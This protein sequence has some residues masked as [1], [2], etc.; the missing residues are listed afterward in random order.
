MGFQGWVLRLSPKVGSNCYALRLG[1]NVGSQGFVD[2][3]TW[4]KPFK[5]EYHLPIKKVPQP[6][7]EDD[8]RNLGFTPF[9][10]K[11]LEW[12]LIQWIWP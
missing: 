11:R 2:M 6:Q 12:F 5:K 4:P 3:A 8:L 7:S 9:L 10:S 1:P